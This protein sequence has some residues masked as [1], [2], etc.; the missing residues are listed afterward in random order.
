[1][2][3]LRDLVTSLLDA[4]GS[5]RDVNFE[6]PTWKGVADLVDLLRVPFGTCAASDPEGQRLPEPL[7]DSVV[8]AATRCDG[9]VQV[10]LRDGKGLFKEVQLWVC[11]EDDKSPFVEIQFFPEDVARTATLRDDFLRWADRAR[12]TL[13][14]SRFYARYENASWQFGDTSSHSGVFLVGTGA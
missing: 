7:R 3:E 13:Q 11:V 5:C 1:M 6:E 12:S 4:D 8:K 2:R 14:A 10:H 9:Y